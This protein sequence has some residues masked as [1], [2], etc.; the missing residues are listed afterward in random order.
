[1]PSFSVQ[2]R[3]AARLAQQAQRRI[4]ASQLQ[5]MS[6]G[7]ATCQ[8][9]GLSRQPPATIRTP[10]CSQS[11][12]TS[13]RLQSVRQVPP[14]SAPSGPQAQTQS[15]QPD[16]PPRRRGPRWVS[17]AIFLLLGLISGTAIRAVLSPPPP[18]LP[19]TELDASFTRDLRAT[20]A[21]LPLVKHLLSDPEWSQGHHEAYAGIPAE[22]RAQRITTGPLGSSRGVGGYQH[23]FHNRATGEVVAVVYLGTGTIGWPGVVHGGAIATLLDEHSARAALKDLAA[24][25]GGGV[26][27][28][29]LDLTYK[30]PTLASDF[31]VL[32]ARA[33]PEE[34]LAPEERGKRGRKIWVDAAVE[35]LDG[36]KCVECRALFVSPKSLKLRTVPEN[37]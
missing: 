36:K 34:A 9:R 11:F 14:N 20:A 17:A 19:G 5:N 32:R 7:R 23:V 22:A 6:A 25:G 31:Y 30:R 35:T 3:L 8:R 2:G 15:S 24:G 10:H 16:P 12:S 21:Q 1:M 33:V 26:L 27:T 4:A 29:N 18:M 37:F 13:L 28:A